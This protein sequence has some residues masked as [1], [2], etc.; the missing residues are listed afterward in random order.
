MPLPWSEASSPVGGG[1]A[2][3][4]LLVVQGYVYSVQLFC[5]F[6]TDFDCFDSSTFCCALLLVLSLSP[7]LPSTSKSKKFSKWLLLWCSV[8]ES[9]SRTSLFPSF[10]SN[11]HQSVTPP[12][13]HRSAQSQQGSPHSGRCRRCP[14]YR[15]PYRSTCL[16]TEAVAEALEEGSLLVVFLC[17]LLASCRIFWCFKLVST[18]FLSSLG[19]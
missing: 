11:Q 17:G 8:L 10:S 14:R 6:K 18:E 15:W 12:S 2:L 7:L 4:I 13:S 5:G 16:G 9:F 3:W 19:V 1:E